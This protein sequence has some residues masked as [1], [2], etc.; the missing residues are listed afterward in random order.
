MVRNDHGLD[1]RRCR[2]AGMTLKI[3]FL[4]CGLIAQSHAIRLRSVDT[5]EIV[6]VFDIDIERAA[7]F[8]EKTGASVAA[9][10]E[11][12]IEE[13][14][15]IYVTTWTSEHPHLVSAIASAGKP[16][17]CEKPLGVDLSTART[18]FDEV[19][20]AGIVNQVGLVLRHSPAF[21][22]MH[23]QM[24]SGEHGP[25][26]SLIFRDD[27]YIPV[28]GAYGSTWRGDRAKAGAGTLLEHSIHDLDLIDW[29]FGPIVRV[30]C[31]TSNTHGID[32]I[33][34]QASV[35]LTARHGGQAI[36]SSTWHDVITR[37][38]L[39]LVEGFC[40]ASYVGLEGDWVG[41]IRQSTAE[42]KQ[43]EW[44]G[45]EVV[46]MASEIDGGGVNPDADFVDSVLS[47]SPAFPDFGVAVRAHVLVDAAYR[48]AE[49][50]G[51]P[52]EV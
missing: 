2:Q 13:A 31:V 46:D 1:R 28:Q 17:F 18:M 22:W 11:Q 21:R 26:M 52:I 29:I 43:V 15:A 41:P 12:V 25:P 42:Q 20:A 14:D 32:G 48:S 19:Q 35:M 49:E 37:P 39:R 8:A 45:Q 40:Q 9:S 16:I 36:L 47:E 51:A 44:Q 38:S 7:S 10:V 34:D 23:D 30:S 5:A 24:S 3:G 4:G 6:L 50:N 27:Q 33:E